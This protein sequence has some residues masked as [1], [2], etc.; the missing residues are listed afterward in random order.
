MVLR[1]AKISG[2]ENETE[3]QWM[4]LHTD[5]DPSSW[6]LGLTIQVLRAGDG[7]SAGEGLTASGIQV[8][9]VRRTALAHCPQ[10]LLR[11][12]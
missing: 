1:I 12:A 4:H 11:R 8:R 9:G 3:S 2:F 5:G 7:Y 6:S 10:A